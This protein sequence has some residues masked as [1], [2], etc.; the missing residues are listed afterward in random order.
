MT[1]SDH[2]STRVEAPPQDLDERTGRLLAKLPQGAGGPLN[3]MAAI[4]HNPDAI[5]AW[6]RFTAS[7]F[8]GTLGGRE[9]ELLILRTAWNVQSSYEWGNHV[10]LGLR[11][12]LTPAEIRALTEPPAATAWSESDA[13]LLAIADEL[14]VDG[15]IGEATWEAGV[16]ARSV[17]ELIEIVFVVG[18][19]HVVRTLVG[20]L[21]VADEPGKPG[22]GE[23][24]VVDD[25]G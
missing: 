14:H 6:G 5:R 9:R 18:V 2:A 12:G 4:I 25:R 23:V 1:P 19:Y 17:S 24:T 13:L 7:L 8:D 16:R 15:E 21:G 20:S 10:E 22:L 3:L 11:A